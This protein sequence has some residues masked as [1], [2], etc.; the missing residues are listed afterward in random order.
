MRQWTKKQNARI[1]KNTI[2]FDKTHP[3]ECSLFNAIAREN[4][5]KR[6]WKEWRDRK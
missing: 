2:S 5:K 6:M 3:E 4:A 1:R